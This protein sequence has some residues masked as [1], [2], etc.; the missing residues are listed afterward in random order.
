MCHRY[1]YKNIKCHSIAH[2]TFVYIP[3]C[4][5]ES[6]KIIIKINQMSLKELQGAG[7]HIDQQQG[8]VHH[9]DGQV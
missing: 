8:K 7:G 1:I 9:E 3:I 6:I 2:Y 4:H 5:T